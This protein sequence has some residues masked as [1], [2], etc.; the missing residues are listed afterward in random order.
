MDTYSAGY[1]RAIFLENSGFDTIFATA[2]VEDQEFSFR[3][4]QKGYRLVFVPQAQVYHTH[5]RVLA[6]Y[7]RRKFYIGYYKALLTRWLPERR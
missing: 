7:I 2:S 5:D 4:A 6:E 3:L 1:R